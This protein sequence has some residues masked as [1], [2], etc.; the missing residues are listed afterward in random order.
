MAFDDDRQKQ[1][2]VDR[3]ELPRDTIE[4]PV[5][6]RCNDDAGDK[7][8]HSPNKLALDLLHSCVA[9]LACTVDHDTAI[10]KDCRSGKEERE[11]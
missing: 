11:I 6:E 8:D 3:I 10:G 5:V 1:D 2:Q 7:A 4:H 9:A